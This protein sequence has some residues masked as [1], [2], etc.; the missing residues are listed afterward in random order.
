MHADHFH[1]FVDRTR[2]TTIGVALTTTTV[3][4]AIKRH[5]LGS[6]SAVILG[7]LLTAAALVGLVQKRG[8]TS[9]QIVGDGQAGQVFADVNDDGALRG[10]MRGTGLAFPITSHTFRRSVSAAIGQGALSVIRQ[11]QDV[12]F[13]QS[14]TD[15]CGGEVDTDVE[16]YLRRSEQTASSLCCDVIYG[17]DGGYRASAGILVQ[18]LPGADHE[19]VHQ[20]GGELRQ[21]F[22]GMIGVSSPLEMVQAWF[23]DAVEVAGPQPIGWQCRCSYERVVSALAMVGPAE[24]ADMVDDKQDTQVTC[25]FCQQHYQVTAEEVEDI[26]LNTITAR[27]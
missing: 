20:L 2:S 5:A 16:A 23:P 18:A 22:S 6:T 27:G 13:A 21:R 7:R 9:L 24:L 17:N 8:P 11:G 19:F 15:L 14:T 12:E 4:E 1:S 3:A 26:F 25:E 10:Y